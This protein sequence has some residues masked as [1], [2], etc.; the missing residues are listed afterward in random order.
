MERAFYPGLATGAPTSARTLAR[1]RPPT[2]PPYPAAIGRI[3]C[4]Y[5]ALIGRTCGPRAGSRRAKWATGAGSQGFARPAPPLALPLQMTAVKAGGH[6]PSLGA[7]LKQ[8]ST[9]DDSGTLARYL[10]EIRRYP[11]LSADE[12]RELAGT[13]RAALVTAN[14][15]F[16]VRIAREYQ[17]CGFRLADL[18]Q[19]GNLGLM[20]AVER[21]DPDRGV[22]LVAYAA[23]WIRA[24]IQGFVMRS[25]SLVKLGTT[26]A[27]RRLYSSLA[28]ARREVERAQRARGLD[29]EVADPDAIARRLSVTRSEVEEMSARLS[30]RD[31]SLDAPGDGPGAE[32]VAMLTA[33][34]S[35]QDH[36]V[37]EA[38]EQ[39]LLRDHVARALVALGERERFI[40]EQR[41]MSD[42]PATLREVGE[43]LG[44]SRERVRQLE[45]R[46]KLKLE[47]VLDAVAESLDWPRRGAP[48]PRQR[49]AA[50]A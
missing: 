21:F 19:E 25:H 12:E 5:A 46:V 38:E 41:L 28:S 1:R 24:Y 9:P 15:R 17:G 48:V 50:E 37:A 11:I 26:V 20:R 36:T 47:V 2:P 42:D 35:T 3:P 29:G 30:A 6:R 16:V 49:A 10:R 33:H 31:L 40:V 22:R 39:E 44:V 43:R 8:T 7:A 4:T 18:I 34:A 13:C 14:L 27:Q 23:W 32:A 45:Q